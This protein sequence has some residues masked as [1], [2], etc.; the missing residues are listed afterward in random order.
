MKMKL[1]AVAAL[2]LAALTGPANAFVFAPVGTSG[3]A[4]GYVNLFGPP[5]HIGCTFDMRWT[6]DG[7][8]NLSITSAV[9]SGNSI[10][11]ATKAAGLPWSATA[12]HARRAVVS[13]VDF[14]IP[15]VTPCGPG[16][17]VLAILGSTV[18][19]E[20][21]QISSTCRVWGSV[22]STPALTITH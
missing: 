18:R 21:T 9:T 2:A 16:S 1:A 8:G 19:L 22:Q 4:H 6:V 3:T 12:K 10:C 15:G 7:S 11:A 20:E 13:G 5:P 14:V 17:D